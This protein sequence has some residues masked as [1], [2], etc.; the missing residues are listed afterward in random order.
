M[1]ATSEDGLRIAVA[2]GKG[3]TGKTTV[4]V[5]LA[6]A[7][8]QASPVQ[9]V[10]CDVEEPNVHLFLRPSITRRASVEIL[11]PQVDEDRCT[12]CGACAAA[13][14][15]GAL[16]VLEGG[17]L[18]HARL[19]H[20]CGLCALVCPAG[21]IAEVPRRIGWIEEGSGE[22]ITFSQGILEVGEP[23]GLPIIEELKARL[24]PGGNVILD[25]PPGTGCPVISALK[26]AQFALLVAEPTPFGLHDLKAAMEVARALGIPAGVVINRDGIGTDEVECHCVREEI[27]VLLR[28]PMDRRI[29]VAYARGVPLTEAFPEWQPRLAELHRDIVK[30]ARG[31]R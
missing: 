13:C 17:V 25:A 18:L 30:C 11:V 16:A 10:D 27:P 1:I 24:P 7:L 29:A 23:M 3:G 20:G 9:L 22:G 6:L 14:R 4:S 15:Y 12:R 28:I 5:A 21:A 26:D 8:R 19:C 31:S 2:S